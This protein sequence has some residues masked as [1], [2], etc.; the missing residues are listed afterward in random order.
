MFF[1]KQQLDKLGFSPAVLSAQQSAWVFFVFVFLIM[2][3][4]LLGGVFCTSTHPVTAQAEV[5]MGKGHSSSS[6]DFLLSSLALT[7]IYWPFLS[8]T[9]L[10]YCLYSMLDS[11]RDC[12]ALYFIVKCQLLCLLPSA[13]SILLICVYQFTTCICIVMVV[14]TTEVPRLRKRLKT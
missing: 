2:L 5:Q 9:T 10:R 6:M 4:D 14:L 1:Y 3:T 7:P 13:I 12:K 8:N 11:L